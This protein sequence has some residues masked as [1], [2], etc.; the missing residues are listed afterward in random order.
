MKNKVT[1][2]SSNIYSLENIK[3][4][5]VCLIGE[6]K[7]DIL[8]ECIHV[9]SI[10]QLSNNIDLYFNTMLE[11]ISDKEM[12]IL[13][14]RFGFGERRY[15]LKEIG[16]IYGLSGERVRQIEAKTIRKLKHPSRRKIGYKILFGLELK[17]E[18]DL[19]LPND[20]SLVT[21]HDLPF[22][23][24]T[25][26]VLTR[27]KIFTLKDL[28]DKNTLFLINIKIGKKGLSEIENF[29]AKYIY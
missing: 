20:L 1:H 29:K 3:R 10:Q 13:R 28:I 6:D 8:N 7:S 14:L 23:I 18:K 9:N 2:K 12:N 26:H 27:N 4:F 22:S 21:I 24:R 11:T 15:T 19:V 16:Q 25:I 17:E 5:F